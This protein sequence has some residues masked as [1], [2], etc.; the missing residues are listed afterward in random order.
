M[1][2]EGKIAIDLD[3]NPA[4][5]ELNVCIHSNRQT[6]IGKVLSGR[7]PDEALALLP[8][9]FSVCGKAHLC[10][11]SS[12]FRSFGFDTGIAETPGQLVV[13]AENARE[14]LLRV[15]LGWSGDNPDA[16]KQLQVKQIM[17]LVA[18]MGVS[19]AGMTDEGCDAKAVLDIATVLDGIL[20]S[21]IFSCEAE[22]WLQMENLTDLENWIQSTDTIAS[23]YLG[24]I[25]ENNWQSVGAA[26]VDFLP[27][28]SVSKL[29]EKLHG[30]EADRYV[31]Q[32]YWLGKTFETGSL[33][34]WHK[35]PLVA[36][37][38]NEYGTGL[39]ARNIARLIELA[40]IPLAMKV[41]VDRYGEANSF[42]DKPEP[43]QDSIVGIKS[44][45]TARGRLVHSL[46]MQGNVIAEYRILAPT[47]WNFH[48]CGSAAK[49][50]QGLDC[51]SDDDLKLRAHM[52]VEAIDPCVDFEVRIS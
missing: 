24:N 25:C 26:D 6:N 22:Q 39:L 41:L 51:D 16:I 33:S 10:V 15:I 2:A 42:A 17:A 50:L 8:L 40:G 46:K 35:H 29:R 34:R 4:S 18:D 28:L 27:E 30:N 19:A 12:V 49:G 11:A 14:H 32:P 47:E 38:I 7:T 21:K 44:V 52:L 1:I 13:L 45:E 5:G 37:I 23:C 48:P 20:N 9:I 3:C 31:A 43:V 36:S